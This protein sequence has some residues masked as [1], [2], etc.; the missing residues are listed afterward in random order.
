[1]TPSTT[2]IPACILGSLIGLLAG[3]VCWR[4]VPRCE[5]CGRT[6]PVA[7]CLDC[8]RWLCRE[9]KPREGL[10]PDCWNTPDG[11]GADLEEQGRLSCRS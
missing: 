7:R 9:C 11:I 6:G 2:I 10:C 1:M 5:R 4:I 8:G 3:A